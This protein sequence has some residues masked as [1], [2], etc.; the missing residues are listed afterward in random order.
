VI[1]DNFVLSIATK[2]S[3]FPIVSFCGRL[4]SSDNA[5]LYSSEFLCSQGLRSAVLKGLVIVATHNYNIVGVL[6]FYP[7]RRKSQISVYQF[8]VDEAFR[9][10]GVVYAM[11]G[12]LHEQYNG[13]IIC[14]C[15]KGLAF[16]NYFDKTG[17]TITEEYNAYNYWKWRNYI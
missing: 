2:T 4:L 6:R 9:G 11:L 15:P 1:N 7:N 14:K 16:N 5:A 17:W 10:Q 8:V 12:F 13:E 3:I